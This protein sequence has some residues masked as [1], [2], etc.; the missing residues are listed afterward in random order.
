MAVSHRYFRENGQLE[1]NEKKPILNRYDID[2]FLWIF[3]IFQMF[4]RTHV[5]NCFF[6]GILFNTVMEF[7]LKVVGGFQP[8][9]MFLNTPS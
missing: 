8:L 2:T 4:L 1:L 7:F 5:Q 6:L 9:N 3:Q